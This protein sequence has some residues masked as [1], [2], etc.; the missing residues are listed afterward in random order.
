MAESRTPRLSAN[1]I[2]EIGAGIAVVALANL[3]FLVYLDVSRTQSNPYFGIL[4][5]IVAPAILIFGIALYVAGILIERRRRRLSAPD[6]VPQY[7]RV[8]LND[9]RTRVLTI[10]TAVGLILFVTMT[11]VGSYQAYHYTDSDQFCG[12]MCHEP[13]HPEYTAYKE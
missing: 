2:S 11:V 4:T 13:M 5:W 6:A 3:G 8:D 1:L 7:P 10:A 9:R 12:T